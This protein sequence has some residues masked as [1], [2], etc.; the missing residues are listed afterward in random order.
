MKPINPKKKNEIYHENGFKVN[1][2]FK[3]NTILI[4]S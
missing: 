3:K 1:Q 4:K 2:I